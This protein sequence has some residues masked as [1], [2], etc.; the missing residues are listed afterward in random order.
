MKRN[1]IATA[2]LAGIASLGLLA[3]GC[4]AEPPAA[5]PAAAAPAFQ[6]GR[7]SVEVRGS[8]PDVV[9]IPGLASSKAVWDATA[10]RLDDTHRVHIVQ[11]NG[12][13]GAAAGANAEGPVVEP[14][15]AELEG[16]I[17]TRGLKRPAVIG[18]S[19][20]GETALLLAARH[21][22]A[23]SRVMVVDALPFF[24]LL[25]NPAATAESVR[26]QANMLRDTM[27]GWNDVQYRTMQSAGIARLVK[28]PE[29]RARHGAFAAA[30]DK[31]VVA[32]VMHEIITLDLRPLLAE[33]TVPITVL[34]AADE[35]TGMPV[36]AFDQVFRNAYAGAKTARLV[37]IDGARHFI[38][39]DQPERF[40]AEVDAF[41]KP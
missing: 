30:S 7:M 41:L 32:R 36:V 34:Y 6:S 40:A 37:R 19:M 27:L 10:D 4:R 35:T 20:G 8:G 14:L 31:S 2:A 24:A 33:T 18:H 16:Y 28:N 25:M 15:V 21:P 12:F 23:V 39:D 22:Q 9:L 11:V 3:G 1:V 26:P 17:R 29:A 5:A 13:A 38:M